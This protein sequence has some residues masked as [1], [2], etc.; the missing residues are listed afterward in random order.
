MNQ[1]KRFYR[2]FLNHFLLLDSD[3][4][5]LLPATSSAFQT[6]ATQSEHM[7]F[8]AEIL[9]PSPSWSSTLSQ[10]PPA[11]LEADIQVHSESDPQEPIVASFPN[12]QDADPPSEYLPNVLVISL[13]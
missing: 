9:P 8:T 1:L 13:P 3:F 10:A 7:L 4:E 11:L 2:V 5:T 6:Q 12:Q